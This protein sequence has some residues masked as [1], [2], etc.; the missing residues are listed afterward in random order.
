MG[1]QLEE[2]DVSKLTD[3]MV[4]TLQPT[5]EKNSNCLHVRV[6]PEVGIMRADITKV[7]Q[8]LLNLISNACKFTNGGDVSLD[9][10]RRFLDGREWIRFQ[11][12]DTGIGIST[13]QQ[14]KLF[15]EFAQGDVSVARKYG[16]TGLGLAISQRFAQLMKGRIEVSSLPGKGST[17]TVHLP[18]E[19]RVD[20]ADARKTE[21]VSDPPVPAART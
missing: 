13:E 8:I 18:A 4:S 10:D 5:V 19:V 15:K 6:A 21:A 20:A 9:V 14:A 16:G 1:M 17:F 12:K 7:R 3:E 11:V 2:F